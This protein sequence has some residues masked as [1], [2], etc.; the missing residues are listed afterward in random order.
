MFTNNHLS[1]CA[2]THRNHAILPPAHPTHTH[3]HGCRAAAGAA[4]RAAG[5]D[6][7]CAARTC[8]GHRALCAACHVWKGGGARGVCL[9]P[10]ACACLCFG[11]GVGQEARVGSIRSV[12]CPSMACI[13]PNTCAQCPPGLCCCLSWLWLHGCSR[14]L[15]CKGRDVWCWWRV[16]GSWNLGAVV[17]VLGGGHTLGYDGTRW[18]WPS[19][20]PGLPQPNTIRKLVSDAPGTCCRFQPL[21]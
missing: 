3:T 13:W 21:R 8:G 5:A 6:G 2:F 16:D 10:G 20:K 1:A 15:H 4:G 19:A 14:F 11:G 7:L 12:R 9:R 17:V 18:A